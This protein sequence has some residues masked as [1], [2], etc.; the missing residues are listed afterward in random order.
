MLFLKSL[1]EEW[2]VSNDICSKTEAFT[3]L[4]FGYTREKR[5]NVVR[6]KMLRKIVDEDNQ[7]TI[8]SKIDLSKLAP[9]EGNLKPHIYHVKHLVA[10]YKRASEPIYWTP[11]PWGKNPGWVENDNGVLELAW[12]LR[13]VLSQSLMDILETTADDLEERNEENKT[14]EDE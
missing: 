11:K 4:M 13:T 10:T 6:A 9:A 7:L 2:S 5:I 14:D 8:R 3:C 1:G 12:S